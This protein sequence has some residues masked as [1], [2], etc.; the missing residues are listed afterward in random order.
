MRP[1]CATTVA[2]AAA[3]CACSAPA[4]PSELPLAE[5]RRR[6]GDPDGAALA[7]RRAQA[8]WCGDA[9]RWRA[10]TACA[11]AQLGEG[12]LWEAAG[13]A[14]RALD[15][16]RRALDAPASDAVAATA[17]LRVGRLELAA[18]RVEPAWHAL[19]RAIGQFPDEPAA[20]DALRLVVEVG[21]DRD[22]RA[23]LHR[24]GVALTELA[25]TQL[26]DNLLWWMAELSERELDEPRA[27]R[28]LYD[29]IPRDTPRSGLR[30]DARWHAARLS[31]ALGD[32][33]GAA[34]RLRALLATREVALGAGSYFSIWLDDAQLELGR[35]L[36]DELADPRGAAAELAR[37]PRDYPASILIDDSLWERALAWR[38]AGELAAACAALRELGRRFASSKFAPAARELAAE[39]R[40]EA[41]P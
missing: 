4:P 16:Y 25:E 18:G 35:L 5:A 8:R 7:Y 2:L 10:V 1:R 39:L 37:L 15:A 12:E 20:A 13:S 6:A 29:R 26:A 21:R 14:E 11:Q 40:C 22:P 34:E 27:A 17:A 41:A 9:A 38:A 3:L 30:D 33:A 32:P 23:L 24:L 19:W 31:R 28:Q 36:R